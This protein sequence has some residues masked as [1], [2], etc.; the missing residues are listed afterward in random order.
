M[1]IA[2]DHW[3]ESGTD[4]T[5][6]LLG[7][8]LAEAERWASERGDDLSPAIVTY[9]SVS[10]TLRERRR[11]EEELQRQREPGMSKMESH[12]APLCVRTTDGHSVYATVPMADN[13]FRVDKMA[14]SAFGMRR[15]A[16]RKHSEEAGTPNWVT[17]LRFSPDGRTLVS[18]S[19]DGTIRL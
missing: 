14:K 4:D 16:N 19:M 10:T 12:W 11:Q 9:I 7:G 18:S 15:V 5:A 1:R 2:F 13:L 17:D 3:K 6:L 8:R